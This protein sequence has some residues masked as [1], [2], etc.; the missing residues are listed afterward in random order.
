[1]PMPRRHRLCSSGTS[2]SLRDASE[3]PAEA[4]LTIVI[5]C[6]CALVYGR[7]GPPSSPIVG[8]HSTQVEA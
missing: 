4:R 2:A 8:I 5:H 1:M 6:H 3:L 7:G